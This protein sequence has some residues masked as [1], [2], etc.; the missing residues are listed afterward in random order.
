[1]GN[2]YLEGR[3]GYA[4]ASRYNQYNK[5]LPID[6]KVSILKFGDDRGEPLNPIF[7]DGAIAQLKLIY[8]VPIP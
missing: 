4:L 1:M 6:L 7:S 5:D 8:S 3:F 2:I